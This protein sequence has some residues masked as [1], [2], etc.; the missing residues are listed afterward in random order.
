MID[1]TPAIRDSKEKSAFFKDSSVHKYFI[2]A[3]RSNLPESYDAMKFLFELLKLNRCKEFKL[4]GDFKCT[5]LILG[6]QSHS[7]KFPCPFCSTF[8]RGLDQRTVTKYTPRTFEGI[9]QQ[10]EA[11]I[12]S[13]KPEANLQTFKNCRR[14]H[15]LK[16]IDVIVP[17]AIITNDE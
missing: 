7:S 8:Q 4:S 10:Y 9:K 14:P 11:W 12:E 6:L 2:V 15:F 3:F 13:G 5:N 16:T 1:T 17:L